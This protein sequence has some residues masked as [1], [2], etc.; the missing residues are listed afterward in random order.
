MSSAHIM[1]SLFLLTKID[2][3]KIDFLSEDV[4]ENDLFAFA[5]E[6]EYVKPAFNVLGLT[7]QNP[8]EKIS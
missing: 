8:W 6:D 7:L 5:D 4:K 1:T 3:A 2:F